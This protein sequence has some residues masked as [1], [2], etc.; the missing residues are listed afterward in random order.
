MK[1]YN[2]QFTKKGNAVF[3]NENDKK[4]KIKANEILRF[5]TAW[6][7]SK[8][9]YSNCT[10]FFTDCNCFYQ[11]SYSLDFF[12]LSDCGELLTTN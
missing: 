1:T 5:G 9:T 3:V 7:G 4:D 2:L 10:G 6:S 11:N 12:K 8:E